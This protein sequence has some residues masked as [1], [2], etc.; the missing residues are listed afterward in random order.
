MI[1]N[2]GTTEHVE[3]YEAQ[4]NVFLIL[5]NCLKVK[6]VAIHILPDVD[7][8]K[9]NRKWAGHC[10]YFY[11]KSFFEMLA[12][13]NNYRLFPIKIMNHLICAGIQKVDEKSFMEDKEKLLHDLGERVKE[14]DCFFISPLH[15]VCP[16]YFVS[17][18]ESDNAR[19]FHCFTVLCP[20][21]IIIL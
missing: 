12:K 17:S 7:E 19:Y 10:N 1:T 5:H 9:I 6:G 11:S 18:S 13:E 16:G 21:F 15:K 8:L 4:Y 3:P 2:C 14:L 20:R